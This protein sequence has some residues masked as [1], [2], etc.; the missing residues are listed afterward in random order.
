MWL[1]RLGVDLAG[2][3]GGG[4]LGLFGAELAL[5]APP[6]RPAS[7][8]I[9]GLAG[10]AGAAAGVV[11]FDRTEDSFH[12]RS[13]TG[14]G[15]LATCVTTSFGGLLLAELA[16]LRVAPCTQWGSVIIGSLGGSFLGME[17]YD[18]SHSPPAPKRDPRIPETDWLATTSFRQS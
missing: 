5:L 2:L 4:A 16:T 10:A 6:L 7:G 1:K 11:Q 3:V 15:C 17:I 9:L 12:P 13:A 18:Q 14:L 8:V